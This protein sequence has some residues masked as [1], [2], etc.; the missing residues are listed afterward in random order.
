MSGAAS[1]SLAI[2]HAPARSAASLAAPEAAPTSSAGARWPQHPVAQN[3]T[4]NTLT[5]PSTSE[6]QPMR[7]RVSG[8]RRR[9]GPLVCFTALA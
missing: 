3:S 5:G 7:F 1:R 2:T 6:I 8:F 4:N 9:A